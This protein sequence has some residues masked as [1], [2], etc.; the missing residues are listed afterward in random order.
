MDFNALEIAT[1]T[2][3]QIVGPATRSFTEIA[4]DSRRVR[5]G[6]LFVALPG[7]RTDGH[8]YIGAALANGAAGALVTR[9]VTAAV[10]GDAV[11][12]RCADAT[13]ALQRL[14]SAWRSRL[15]GTVI[16]IAGSNG[17]T[18]TK[19]TLA[20]VLEGAGK[21]FA[22][23]GNE[24]S[25]VGAPVALL[26]APVDADFVVLE[27]GTSQP[28]ELSRLAAMAR[29]DH[30]IVTAAFAE[31]LEWLR[32]VAGVI[33]AE[34]E[35]L[36]F[37]AA[38]GLALVGSAERGLV[39]AARRHSHLRLR[40]VGI[41]ADDD[42]RLAGIRLGRDGTRFHLAGEAGERDW[43]VPLLGPPAAWAAAFAIAIARTL[44][45]PDDVIQAGLA[46][47]TPAAHRL[48]A[49]LTLD[50]PWLV[51]D[52]CYNSNPASCAAALAT[53][54]EL[55]NEG[56][57]LL[58][59]LGD[60][61]ELGEAT[62]EAHREVGRAVPEAAPETDLLLTVGTAAREIAAA[63]SEGGIRT[64][65]LDDADA[66]IEALRPLLADGKPTT[67]LIKAS[68]GVGLDRVVAAVTSSR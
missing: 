16:G 60:M 54:V 18:T 4:I 36:E 56:E 25:Q 46:K 34:T 9:D 33:S 45:S 19:E 55:R 10:R 49:I 27:L 62:L 20:K 52:D 1:L 15:A 22:T 7:A 58:L 57:R 42:W 43:H 65:S 41:S 63:A 40:S 39:A 64:R 31:H 35:I 66:A 37:T 32:D 8:E 44:G 50:R 59:V 3:G 13:V 67:I 28:G 24:N 68:R 26:S 51:I 21:V 53:A 61:L 47:L 6:C 11:L 12:I 38:G 14:A 17:K 30:A 48:T 2:D 29:P 5:P 23:P